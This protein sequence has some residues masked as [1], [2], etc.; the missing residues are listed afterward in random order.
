MIARLLGPRF[1][2]SEEY[3]PQTSDQRRRAVV[4][5]ASTSITRTKLVTEVGARLSRKLLKYDSSRETWEVVFWF[6]GGLEDDPHTTIILI[7]VDINLE[8]QFKGLIE[9]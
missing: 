9:S 7:D 1:S 6:E 8:C 2:D 4:D 3:D 5:A